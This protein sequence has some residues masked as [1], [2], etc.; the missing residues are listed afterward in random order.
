MQRNITVTELVAKANDLLTQA[1]KASGIIHFL[2]GD[3]PRF[4]HEEGYVGS[5]YI[6]GVHLPLKTPGHWHDSF[7]VRIEA[8]NVF[9]SGSIG[10]AETSWSSGGDAGRS[11]PVFQAMAAFQAMWDGGIRELTDRVKDVT[12]A[13]V[14][15]GKV[16]AI[17][18]EDGNL[19]KDRNGYVIAYASPISAELVRKQVKGRE[20]IPMDGFLIMDRFGN[21]YRERP[22]GMMMTVPGYYALESDA[23]KAAAIFAEKNKEQG[24]QVVA[25]SAATEQSEVTA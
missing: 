9:H 22:G 3:L 23:D 11:L 5:T 21:P 10:L 20:V 17:R 19:T 18:G 2:R 12:P 16:F 8:H 24:A 25:L 4:V 7:T 6:S 13:P 1:A 14:E 15:D